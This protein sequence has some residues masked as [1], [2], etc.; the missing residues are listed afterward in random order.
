MKFATA[1]VFASL[2]SSVLALPQEHQQRSTGCNHDNCYRQMIQ[3]TASV[4]QFCSTYTTKINT[5]TTGLPT[6]VANC[7]N[8]PDRISSA[9]SCLA[10]TSTPAPVPKGFAYADGWKFKVDG[11]PFLF[12]GSNAYW[13]P[14]LQASKVF[15]W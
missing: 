11:K 10:P 7:Q 3:N 14:F 4:T 2:A 1:T 13:L 15:Y 12:A 5:A 8:S 9:C 6:W